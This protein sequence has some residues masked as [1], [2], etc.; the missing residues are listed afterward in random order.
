[1]GLAET[2]HH[3]M[4]MDMSAQALLYAGQIVTHTY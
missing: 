4:R 3:N 1:M 2:R